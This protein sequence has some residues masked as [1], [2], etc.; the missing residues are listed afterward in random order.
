MII[1]N[2]QIRMNTDNDQSLLLEAA[3]RGD[4]DEVQRLVGIGVNVEARNCYGQT[5]LSNAAENG[6][7][8]VV[9][10]LMSRGADLE[11]RDNC[12]RTPSLWADINRKSNIVRFLE[13]FAAQHQLTAVGN[14][15]KSAARR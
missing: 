5:P 10:F 2:Q 14:L 6:N 13:E 3:T 8:N 1:S 15:T 12:G 9:E 4:L 11:T 7:L